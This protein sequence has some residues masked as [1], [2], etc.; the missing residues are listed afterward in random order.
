MHQFKPTSN[1]QTNKLYTIKSVSC[2]YYQCLNI[3]TSACLLSVNN[4]TPRQ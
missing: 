3:Y 2:L 4:G 1:C